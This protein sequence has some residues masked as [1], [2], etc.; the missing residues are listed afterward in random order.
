MNLDN[1]LPLALFRA[2]MT[3]CLRA[4]ELVQESRQRWLELADLNTRREVG[5]A[6]TEVV[7]SSTAPDWSALASV[8]ADAFWRHLQRSMLV[9]QETLLTAM[10]NQAAFGAGMQRAVAE[11]Q[12]EAAQAVSQASNAMPLHTTLAEMLKGMGTEMSDDTQ[13]AKPTKA[14]R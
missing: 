9:S 6:H 10:N 1:Q 13:V 14:R 3:L 2:Q 11:W 4:G 7:D 8:P 5:E 12:R